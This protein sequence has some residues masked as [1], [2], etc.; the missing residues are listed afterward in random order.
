MGVLLFLHRVVYGL[1]GWSPPTRL[2]TPCVRLLAALPAEK[3]VT[4]PVAL[5]LAEIAFFWDGW[6][7]LLKRMGVFVLILLPLLAMLSLVERPHAVGGQALG[8]LG[9]IAKY[10]EESGL[11]LTQAVIS[12]CRVLFTYLALIVALVRPMQFH[13]TWIFSRRNLIIA[14]GLERLHSRI[15]L[16]R[17]G[18]S[19]FGAFLS[20]QSGAGI[21]SRSQVSL[22]CVQSES[23]HVWAVADF[24]RYPA[25]TL[26]KGRISYPPE[27]ALCSCCRS[28]GVI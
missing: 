7:S 16:I 13:R 22:F 26:G 28:A 24:G 5:V 15:V 19:G 6:K 8:I 12:Q 2:G 4:L 20:R 3:A 1:F 9:T 14:L 25:C 11:T 23:A 21:I 27:I 18:C 10:Y 17:N